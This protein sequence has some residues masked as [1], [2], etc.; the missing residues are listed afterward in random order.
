MRSDY[1]ASALQML[2]YLKS[3]TTDWDPNT[4]VLSCCGLRFQ[5]PR[6]RFKTKPKESDTR[7]RVCQTAVRE[8]QTHRLETQSEFIEHTA[9]PVNDERCAPAGATPRASH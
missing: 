7:P 3:P 9:V 1:R 5:A 4:V 8:F 2:A 6:T